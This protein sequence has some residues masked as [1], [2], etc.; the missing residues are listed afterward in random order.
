MKKDKQQ[1]VIL[2]FT[3][4]QTIKY[5]FSLGQKYTERGGSGSS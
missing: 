5:T 2:K 1:G 3:D 4:Q